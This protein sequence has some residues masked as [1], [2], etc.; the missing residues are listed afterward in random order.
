MIKFFGTPLKEITS[1]LTNKVVFRFDSNG[2]F[3]T[4]DP[5]IIKRAMGHFD[6]MPVK[7][8]ATGE[9][10]KKT[11]E[12]ETMTI[13]NKEDKELSLT[14]KVEEV[15][16]EVEAVTEKVDYSMLSYNELRKL[17]KEKGIDKKN[18]TKDELI[19]GLDVL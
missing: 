7:I 16:E 18:P 17:A 8:E 6:Y 3:V 13:T 10:V 1:K 2:E 4:E 9:K 15:A 14:E 19:E 11:I 5:E 12:A